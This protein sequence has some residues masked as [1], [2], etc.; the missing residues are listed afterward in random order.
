M[1]CNI[2]FQAETGSGLRILQH[3][4]LYDGDVGVKDGKAR[5]EFVG[6]S[7]S[8]LC[9]KPD[10]VWPKLHQALIHMRYHFLA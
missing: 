3:E 9:K 5:V 1:K 8:S 10:L 6:M 2:S 4:A 7:W